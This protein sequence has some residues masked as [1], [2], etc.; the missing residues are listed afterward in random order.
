MTALT[1]PIKG[2]ASTRRKRPVRGSRQWWL[3]EARQCD[4]DGHPAAAAAARAQ[5]EQAAPMAA[6]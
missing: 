2:Q 6:R 4:R 5:A 1:V 3:A